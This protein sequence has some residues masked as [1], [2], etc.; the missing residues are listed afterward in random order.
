M[1]TTLQS[2]KSS[3]NDI[4]NEIF[5]IPLVKKFDKM[6]KF[7]VPVSKPLTSS[8]KPSHYSLTL[9]GERE[10]SLR[11]ARKLTAEN[12]KPVWAEFSIIS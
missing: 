11:G 1:L 7:Q 8:S 6:E 5:G 3:D 10:S 9:S 2:A 4:L 12:L